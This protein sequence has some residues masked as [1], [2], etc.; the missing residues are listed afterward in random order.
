MMILGFLLSLQEI[1]SRKCDNAEMAKIN[2]FR[3]ETTPIQSLE[4]GNVYLI[5][6]QGKSRHYFL[7]SWLDLHDSN[8]NLFEFPQYDMEKSNKVIFTDGL[9]NDLCSKAVYLFPAYE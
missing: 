2:A 3:C 8:R 4:I 7:C 1:P 6:R 5:A 9:D